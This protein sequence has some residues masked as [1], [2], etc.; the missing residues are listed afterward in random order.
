MKDELAG[1]QKNKMFQKFEIENAKTGEAKFVSLK[2]VEL[3]QR[4][5]ILDQTLEYFT[6]NRE[7]RRTRHS[8]EKIVKEKESE[9]KEN[10]KS[11]RELLKIAGAETG[12]YKQKSFFSAVK[13]NHAPVFTPKELMTLEIR[14]RETENKSEATKLQKIL[15]STN[16]ERA[17]NLSAILA[18][19]AGENKLS[20]TADGQQYKEQTETK[21]VAKTEAQTQSNQVEV[22]ENKILNEREMGRENKA[23]INHQERSR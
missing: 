9:L 19:A 20:K 22:S 11:S 13:Y 5:S 14:I 2:E 18:N 10:L 6:E 8:L 12:D 1:F 23:V 7:K 3:N 21:F 4:G 16:Y 17:K 15:D